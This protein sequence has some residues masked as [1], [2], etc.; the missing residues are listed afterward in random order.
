ME[1]KPQAILNSLV[2]VFPSSQVEYRY[3]NMLHKF[4]LEQDGNPHWLYV[5]YEFVA[6]YTERELVASL[7]HWKI[8]EAFLNSETSRW[9]FLSEAGVREVDDRFGRGR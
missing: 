9:L 7:S 2:A 6:D 8:P 1:P 4:R 3:E 5:A